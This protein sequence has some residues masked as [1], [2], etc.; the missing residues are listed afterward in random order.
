MNN[1]RE[2]QHGPQRPSHFGEEQNV[3]VS[4]NET[5]LEYPVGT[6]VQIENEVPYGWV[7]PMA[8]TPVYLTEAPPK[9][10]ALRNWS[11]FRAVVEARRIPVLA[12]N[13]NRVRAVISNTDDTASIYLLQDENIQYDIAGFQLKPGTSVEMFHNAGV[14]AVAAGGDGFATIEVL[15]EY[16]VDQL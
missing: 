7:P 12:K 5:P 10:R 11:A 14:W 9:D 6:D 4:R 13:R 15:M 16:E 2:E 8:S 3:R 1:S